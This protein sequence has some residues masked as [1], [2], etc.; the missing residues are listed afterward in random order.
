MALLGSL[1]KQPAE[2]LDFDISYVTV[3]AGRSDIIVTK[4]T[5]VTPTGLTV[6]ASTINASGNGIKVVVSGGTDGV[7]Y[8]VTVTATSN[9]TPALIYEDEVTVIVEEI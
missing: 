6:A 7:T 8:I 1:T 9:A 5:A 2:V 3:L 4:A